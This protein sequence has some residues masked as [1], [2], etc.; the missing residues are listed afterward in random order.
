[1]QNRLPD[2]FRQTIPDEKVLHKAKLLSALG[3]NTVCHL[4]HCPNLNSCFNKGK[5]TFMILGD[6]CTRGCR[7]CAVT[8]ANNMPLG[9]DQNEPR[10]IAETVKLLGLRYVVITSVTRDDLNDGGSEIFA[11]T[12]FSV[13]RLARHIKIEVLIPDFQGSI[14]SLRCVLGASPD[15]VSHNIETVEGLYRDLRPQA[16]YQLSLD[17]L[18]AIKKISPKTITKSSLM[19]GLGEKENEVLEA[20]RDLRQSRCDILTLGQYL[21]PSAGHY[22]VKEFISKEQFARY[23]EKGLNLG[24]KAV[25]SGPLVRSSYQADEVFK[26]IL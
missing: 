20:M 9:I 17:L 24:F 25:L 8:K 2:W 22:P 12:I 3:I 4:A 19:L 16:D 5:L 10:R 13:R 21:A 11:K 15:V 14:Y 1:M 26:E 7:F 18:G 6:S 23:K